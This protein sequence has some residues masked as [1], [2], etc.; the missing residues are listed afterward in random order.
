[1]S[2]D[3]DDDGVGGDVRAG[4]RAGDGRAMGWVSMAGVGAMQWC[5]Q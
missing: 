2:T 3:D 1:M 4:G 5:V